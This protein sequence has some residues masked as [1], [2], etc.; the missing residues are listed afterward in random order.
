ML[1]AR[2]CLILALMWLVMSVECGLRS[3]RVRKEGFAGFPESFAISQFVKVGRLVL[4]RVSCYSHK[5]EIEVF[6]ASR[7]LFSSALAHLTRSDPGE[8]AFAIVT[9][10][11]VFLSYFYPQIKQQ[12][13]LFDQA[14][15]ASR[16]SRESRAKMPCSTLSLMRKL[17]RYQC[18]SVCGRAC[19]GSSLSQGPHTHSNESLQHSGI[20]SCSV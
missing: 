12:D 19:G 4:S 9:F 3:I 20:V 1:A 11:M 7:C 15:S 17:N 13:V 16:E 6:F 14:V 18:P 8:L 10:A 5:E 2:V